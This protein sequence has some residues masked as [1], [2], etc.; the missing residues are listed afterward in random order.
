[1]PPNSTD[2]NLLGE[3]LGKLSSGAAKT[4]NDQVSS[5]EN[6]LLSSIND[7]SSISNINRNKEKWSSG[8]AFHPQGRYWRIGGEWYDFT[9]FAHPGGKEI[10]YLARDRFDDATYAFESHHLDYKRARA[11]IRKYKLARPL[12]KDLNDSHPVAAPKLL[13]DDSFYSDVRRRVSKY[14]RTR[15]L[16]CGPNIQCLSLFWTV[17]SL[18]TLSHI[19][20][21]FWNPTIPFAML[22]GLFSC[23]LG[24]LGH[25]FVHQPKYKWMAYLCLDTIGMSSDA[26]YRE[27]VLQHHMYTNTPL[28]NHFKGTDPFLV[29]DPTVPRNWL[30]TYIT[31]YINPIILFFGVWGNFSFHTTELLKGREKIT[32]W[33]LFFP[34]MLLLYVIQHGIIW[35]AVLSIVHV[36]T[37]GT[38]Y[39]TNALMNHNSEHCWDVNLRNAQKDWGAA[40]IVSCADWATQASFL[41][42]MKYLWLNYHC[43]HHL[44]PLIDICHHKEVQII[45][46]QACKDHDIYYETGTFWNI[47]WQMVRSFS[48]PLSLW[49]EINSYN[50]S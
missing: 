25:D 1:M 49:N 5:R 46:M 37:L 32:A 28:D 44:F 3:D 27:H 31:P 11:I 15:K 13:G 41:S 20:L 38:Y 23:V 10:L 45:V 29:C 30:Q 39:F 2:Y 34:C 43:V 33:K 4:L 48:T 22:H 16:D 14:F 6:S 35:G 9:E 40:Q 50:G 36:G 42:S 17:L 12:Q 8:V 18:W 19:N 26:W 47:Y 7:S 21:L 24:A